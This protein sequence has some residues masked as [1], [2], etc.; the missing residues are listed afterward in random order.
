MHLLSRSA[1]FPCEGVIFRQRHRGSEKQPMIALLSHS[2]D[3]H[4]IAVGKALEIDSIDFA[5]IFVDVPSTLATEVSLE[6]S[7]TDIRVGNK[8]ARHLTIYNR[9]AL[10][11]LQDRRRS[12]SQAARYQATE[13]PSVLLGL[14]DLVP[15][16]WVNHPAQNYRAD[17]KL[18]QLRQAAEL[19]FPVPRTMLT[20][21]VAQ[22]RRFYERVGPLVFKSLAPHDAYNGRF[23][24]TSPVD[25]S[26]V[27]AA[28]L[29]P[30]PA[31]FQE[32]VDKAADIRLTVVG[33]RMIGARLRTRAEEHIDWRVHSG[34]TKWERWEVPRYMARFAEAM[35]RHFS[36][37]FA[38][39]DFVQ[40][41]SG[42]L[43]FLELNPNGQWLWL[44]VDTEQDI[45]GSI[46]DLLCSNDLQW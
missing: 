30:C 13:L 11:Y 34:E 45:A 46:A 2:A 36:L 26:R 7:A 9:R 40:D 20:S 32:R 29:R 19:S 3:P 10:S 37:S 17:Q 6:E 41:Q 39:F 43:F 18:L 21:S 24:Y 14:L 16:C 42:K 1:F 44:Q 12:A 35:M 4:C 5:Y 8:R 25:V 15:S 22:L 31:L 28:D 23:V 38:A 27:T 33:D